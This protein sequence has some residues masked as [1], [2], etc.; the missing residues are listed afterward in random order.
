[1]Q[2]QL[3][4]PEGW[5]FGEA[6]AVPSLRAF[7]TALDEKFINAVQVRVIGAK[8]PKAQAQGL[9]AGSDT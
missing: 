6:S 5:G 8:R 3:E 1:V 7:I 4:C 9:R 2:G